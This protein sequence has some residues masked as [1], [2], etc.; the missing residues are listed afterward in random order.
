MYL[1][2]CSGEPIP[3]EELKRREQE[4][5]EKK[6]RKQE[7][8]MRRI[9]EKKKFGSGKSSN[10]DS[11]SRVSSLSDIDGNNSE[12][13][14][15]VVG[16]ESA[17]G[18]HSEQER[19]L[20]LSAR[21]G[22]ERK[23]QNGGLL[24]NGVKP[25]LLKSAFSIDSLLET[26]KVPRGRRPNSKYPRVQASKS[27]NPL[28]LGMYP[29]YPITQPVGFQV[30][31]PQTPTAA[32]CTSEE[33]SPE[34]LKRFSSPSSLKLTKHPGS[35][36]TLESQTGKT[37]NSKHRKEFDSSKNQD[38]DFRDLNKEE[39]FGSSVRSS[40]PNRA[41]G[42]ASAS[43]S[44]ILLPGSHIE[45]HR[46]CVTPPYVKCVNKDKGVKRSNS[47]PNFSSHSDSEQSY[48]ELY[49]LDCSLKGQSASR[50]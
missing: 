32:S 37:E 20:D 44:I 10:V 49:A 22:D 5:I 41:S 9:E 26:P 31:R 17:D 35:E 39:E 40:I 8:R 33:P 29:L 6:K 14:I 12:S 2:T 27:M 23:D 25:P 50:L 48:D 18:R 34:P 7:E 38:N 21:S 36:L 30:E 24:E 43:S 13:E 45:I 3:P 19:E 42:L 11:S 4:R 47:N 15:D 1:Q 16:E 46:K 28:S